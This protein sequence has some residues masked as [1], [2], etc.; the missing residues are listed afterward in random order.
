[1]PALKNDLDIRDEL[2]GLEERL[3]IQLVRFVGERLRDLL[4]R[5]HTASRGGVL[6]RRNGLNGQ[7]SLIRPISVD[8]FARIVERA[9]G[10]EKKRQC[11]SSCDG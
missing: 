6:S 1:M 8:L 5:Y 4:D 11:R 9:W 7:P 10:I 3:T 2:F